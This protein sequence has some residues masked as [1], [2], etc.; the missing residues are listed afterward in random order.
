MAS[1]PPQGPAEPANRP[2][3]ASPV[4]A[5]SEPPPS[6]PEEDDPLAETTTPLDLPVWPT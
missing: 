6:E 4:P 3:P 5:P 1:Q 2:Q